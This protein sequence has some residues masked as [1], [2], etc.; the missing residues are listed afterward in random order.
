MQSMRRTF[1]KYAGYIAKSEG[2]KAVEELP[3]KFE[4]HNLKFDSNGYPVVPAPFLSK[5][6]NELAADMR[7]I[8]RCYISKHYGK[9]NKQNGTK[10]MQV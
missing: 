10:L 6:G 3:L 5:N 1:S 7:R 2:G 4:D 9:E 8:I